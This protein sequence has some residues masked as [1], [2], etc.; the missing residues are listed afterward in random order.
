LKVYIG[1]FKNWVGPYQIVDALFFWHERYPDDTLA[2]RWDYRLHDRLGDWLAD[3]PVAGLC[4]WIES[5]R[6]RK[7]RIRIDKY[8]TWNMDGTLSMIALPM[9]RQLHETKHGAPMTDDDDVPEGF[10]L[11]STEADA[12]KDEWDVDGNHF[13]RWDW[14][15]DEMIWTFEQLQ[16]DCDW[17]A[18]YYT[19]ESDFVFM[20][21]ENSTCGEM[22]TGPKHTRVCDYD[23]LKAHDDRIQNG[24]RLFGKY[25][26]A[27]WD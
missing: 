8:D 25:F 23:G 20:P 16:P 6:H 26:R 11:R 24:L 21:V 9:L 18:Q 5:K 14:I 19:G 1:P 22:V 13:R 3:T 12:K 7:V 27:L 15:M 17:E 4:Q 2:K 10:N